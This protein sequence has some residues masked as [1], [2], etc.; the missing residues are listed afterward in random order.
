[1]Q[2]LTKLVVIVFALSFSV[3]AQQSAPAKH[4]LILFWD[5][6]DQAANDQF[7][8]DFQES[9][10]LTAHRDIEYYFEYL[11]SSRFPGENQSVFLRDYLQRKYAGRII[12]VVVASASPAVDFLFKYRSD[13]FPHTPIVFAGTQRP[14][15][16]QLKSGAGATGILYAD[17]YRK[18][19][20]LALRLQPNTDHVFIVSGTAPGVGSWE[21]MARSDLQGFNSAAIT[22][23]TDLPVDQLKARLRTL[24]DR[25]IVLYVWQRW[26]NQQDRLVESRDVLSLIAPSARVPIYGMS[27]WNVGSGTVGGYVWTMETNA[28]KVAEL[29][30]KILGGARP[31]EIPV[32]KAPVVPMFDWR[33]L[34]RWGIDEDR[35]PPDSIVHFRVL[36]MWQQYR[37]RIIAAI[38]IFGLQSLLIS[39][40]LLARH[41]ARQGAI[42][43]ADAQRVLQES[44]ERFR[45]M[46]DTAPVLIWVSGPD[47][48]CSFFNKGWLT[49]TGRAMEHERANGW[50]EGVHPDDRKQC[51]AAYNS[52]FQAR[53]SFE[54]EYRLRRTDGEYRWV[55]HKGSPRYGLDGEFTGYIGSTIDITD[56]KR[57]RDEAL[58]RQKLDSLTVLTRGI[59]HDFNNLLSAILAEAELADMDQA[60]DRFPA[61]GIQRIKA[62]V[63][64][65]AEIVR[66]LST[67]SGQEEADFEPVDLA[68]LVEEMLGLLKASIFKPVHLVVDIRRPLP[69]VECNPAQIRQLLMNLII[70]ASHAIG[71]KQG[72]IKVCLSRAPESQRSTLQDGG[73]QGEF[74]RF[75]VSDTGCGMTEAEQAKIFDPFFTTKPG[76]HGLGLAVVRGIVQTHRGTIH[77]VS[78]PES[79]TTFKVRL[80]C[81][82]ARMEVASSV[83]YGA[84]ANDILLAPKRVLLIDDEDRSGSPLQRPYDGEALRAHG[85]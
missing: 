28:A 33:E 27:R 36:T 69:V 53:Q 78:S 75:E 63:I 23:L 56:F 6:R 46:A 77:V 3:L 65:A 50:A 55:L 29:T 8:R 14:S 44:E 41:R 5:D 11:E 60:E 38:A 47:K 66:Q 25:S 52:S 37:W 67:Y 82:P 45:T 81:E 24:P 71:D 19:V 2:T 43:L 84:P 51:L 31:A 15:G 30:L 85:G 54:M 16:D 13:L 74:V 42:A 39:W 76:G 59:A 40:L 64:R 1:M 61:E 49:F 48:R 20:D 79:G 73:S 58:S 62:T 35:L 57:A 83:D 18:T 4:V 22:Y 72:V 21:T 17:S 9:L 12:D 7:Q 80:P 32:E 34:Q 26:W 10:R 70:N 68:G